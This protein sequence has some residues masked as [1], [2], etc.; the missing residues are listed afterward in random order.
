MKILLV[1][2]DYAKYSGEEAVVD[3]MLVTFRGLGHEVC[4]LRMTTAGSRDNLTGK[5]KGFMA[6]LYSPAGVKAMREILEK[7]KPDVVNVHNLFPFISPAALQECKKMNIPVVMTVHNYRLIC[8]TGLF[9]RNYQPCEYCLQKGNE[10]GCVKFNCERSLLKSIGYASRNFLARIRK[11]YIDCVDKFACLTQFQG[12]KLIEA[13]FDP[14]KITVIPNSIDVTEKSEMEG[15]YV[16]YAGRLS[17]EKGIP[18]ILEAARKNPDIPF[19]LAGSLNNECSFKKDLENLPNVELTGHLSGIEFDEFY[20]NASFFVMASTCY[21]GFPMAI[22]EAGR[23]GK[24]FIGPAHGGF[25]EILENIGIIFEPG[26]AEALQQAIRT[27]WNDKNKIK[28]LGN[29]TY[30]KIISSYSTDTVAKQ[31]NDLLTL[32][33]T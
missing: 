3:K 11:D 33:T 13:G 21:E 17:E 19:K 7:E 30:N 32:L 23:Y 16:A 8:P 2:N 22:L 15:Q 25:P 27:L 10:W 24:P 4:Q 31:W 5:I 6:G 28:D 12:R 26:N 1:H 14:D 9:L 20:K 18:L 29:K